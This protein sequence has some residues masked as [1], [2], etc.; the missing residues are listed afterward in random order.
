MRIAERS[1]PRSF[2]LGGTLAICMGPTACFC[3]G[4]SEKR[5][6]GRP[7]G[8]SH[9]SAA[10]YKTGRGRVSG[11][12]R[13]NPGEGGNSGIPPLPFSLRRWQGANTPLR[14][15]EE[16]GRGAPGIGRRRI[17]RCGAS[18]DFRS[19]CSLP[20]ENIFARSPFH[21]QQKSF[22]VSLRTC[23]HGMGYFAPLHS[24]V[25]KLLCAAK[26]SFLPPS[27]PPPT[28]A[29]GWTSP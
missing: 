23:G 20:R 2:S 13:S 15:G 7:R 8:I 14:P 25:R 19:A 18:G 22:R 17:R 5:A 1:R 6:F 27:L 9:R 29:V 4:R 24:F 11:S 3:G 26:G 16:E 12:R 10:A 21:P 28:R